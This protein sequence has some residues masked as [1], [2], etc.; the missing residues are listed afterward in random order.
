[1][2]IQLKFFICGLFSSLL[3]PPFFILPIGFIVFP[4]LF[5]LLID[6]KFLNKNKFFQ[7]NSG[8]IYGLGFNLI[9]L[10][11][12]KEPFYINKNTSSFSSF[13]YLLVF[14][15]SIFYG[16]IFL[17]IGFFKNYISKLIIIPVLFVLSEVLR[18]NIS[19]GFPWITFAS[20]YSGNKIILNLIGSCLVILNV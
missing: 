6:E 10:I 5:Y 19:F 18:E 1:M 3:F 17:I 13:S 16:F 8:I 15:C 4:I 20:V 12:I 14:Y 11:W 2:K 9:I 7:F